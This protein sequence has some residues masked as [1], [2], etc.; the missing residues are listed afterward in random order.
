MCEKVSFL[1]N[2]VMNKLTFST[3]KSSFRTKSKELDTLC[4]GE[5]G[6]AEAASAAAS[7]TTT[8]NSF[9]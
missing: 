2:E 9:S 7:K 4:M 8:G 6:G 3:G 1:V 5:E